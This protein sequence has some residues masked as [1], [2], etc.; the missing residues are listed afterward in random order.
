[1]KKVSL[2]ELVADKI[3]FSI[4]IAMYYWMWARNDWKDYYTTVQDVIFAF[5]FYYFVSRAIRVKKYKQESPDEMAEAN[6]WRCD[7]ICLKISVAAFIVIGFTCAVGRMVLTM[8]LSTKL[9]EYREAK[10]LKQADLAELVGVRRETIVNLEKGK[11][12]PSLK[13]AMD[14]AKVFHTTVEELFFFDD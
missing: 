1:M 10:G 5:S 3:I 14:I 12:N 11:Y 2:R 13:L 9:K 4:L 6:L 7:A 8:A